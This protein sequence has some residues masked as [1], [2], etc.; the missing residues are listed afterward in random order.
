[1]ALRAKSLPQSA[2]ANLRALGLLRQRVFTSLSSEGSSAVSQKGKS[3]CGV[4]PGGPS[5]LDRVL[6]A[7]HPV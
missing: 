5:S 2:A 7:F 6:W 1:M 4:H 3:C